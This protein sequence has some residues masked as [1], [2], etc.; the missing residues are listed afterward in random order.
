MR[1]G[2]PHL[3][4]R[5]E[6]EASLRVPLFALTGHLPGPRLVVIGPDDL[7]RAVA[8]IFWDKPD[9]ANIRGA[10]VLR[11]DDQNPAFDRPSETMKLD[12]TAQT[13]RFASFRILGRMTSLGMIQS[14]FAPRRRVA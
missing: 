1:Q 8:D 5:P 6:T 13:A 9:L 2:T 14:R 11:S 12:G 7:M 4:A 3:S 10:L